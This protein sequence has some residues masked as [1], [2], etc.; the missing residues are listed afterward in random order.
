MKGE[1]PVNRSETFRKKMARI[2]G[3]DLR[4]NKHVNIALT[5]IYG[6]RELG[7]QRI[8]DTAKVEP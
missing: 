2:S 7:S 3:V 5:Y 1:Q 6:N 4:G 8:L